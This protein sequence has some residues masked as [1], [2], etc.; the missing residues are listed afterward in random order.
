MTKKIK[1][2]LEQAQEHWNWLKEILNEQ[3]TMERKLY[4]SA[5]LHGFK[6]GKEEKK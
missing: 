5:F 3:R 6:H 1:T 4:I 2:S